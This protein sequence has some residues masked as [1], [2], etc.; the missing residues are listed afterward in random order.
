MIRYSTLALAIMLTA[1]NATANSTPINTPGI[2]SVSI[3][4]VALEANGMAVD[5]TSA[6]N[7]QASANKAKSSLADT[8]IQQDK[9]LAKQEGPLGVLP[10]FKKPDFG[11]TADNMSI[12]TPS[13]ALDDE[14]LEPPQPVNKSAAEQVA[15]EQ[16]ECA[17]YYLLKAK[18]EAKTEAGSKQKASFLYGRSKTALNKA[19]I[20]VGNEQAY[21]LMGEH[22]KNHV[23]EIDSDYRYMTRL[24][25]RLEGPCNIVTNYPSRRIHEITADNKLPL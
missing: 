24:D 14:L 3:Q 21:P 7:A 6:A 20:H 8:L 10:S 18:R 13:I 2:S 25:R 23:N 11:I 9:E 16:V 17:A 12:S 1:G 5:R 4:A 22:M 15:Y 19:K